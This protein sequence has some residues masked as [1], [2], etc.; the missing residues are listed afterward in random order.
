[1]RKRVVAKDG[2]AARFAPDNRTYVFTSGT[3]KPVR[4]STDA[5]PSGVFLPHTTATR[6]A[7]SPDSSLLATGDED[8][9]LTLWSAPSGVERLRRGQ[10][11]KTFGTFGSGKYVEWEVSFADNRTLLYHDGCRLHRLDVATGTT[12]NISNADLCG[13]LR[14]SPNNVWLVADEWYGLL[15]PK[16]I[17]TCYRQAFQLDTTNGL[18]TKLLE[19][20]LT[21][22][23]L[24][25]S[26][27]R[28]VLTR[29]GPHMTFYDIAQG[30][31]Q[32]IVA[33]NF[34]DTFAVDESGMHVVYAVKTG[35]SFPPP[36]DLYVA[37]LG[38]RTIRR[39][40]RLSASLRWW[41]FVAPNRFVAYGYD[42]AVLYD[43][44]QGWTARLTPQGTDNSFLW[45]I[46][47]GTRFM[48]ANN[49]A[50]LLE[51]TPIP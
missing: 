28:I 27:A 15:P 48:L 12:T 24:A 20:P 34:D 21:G 30:T 42:G 45:P 51:F 40:G 32:E 36:K 3:G 16:C 23:Q 14:H 39:L 38:T 44:A 31:E 43:L 11:F 8:G 17:P 13:R 35:T 4:L 33:D 49:F 7:F 19:G 18:G 25:R 22:I 5:N 6:T 2:W 26:G 50:Q 37:D 47:D 41:Q 10:A 29:P 46:P 9:T 1:V